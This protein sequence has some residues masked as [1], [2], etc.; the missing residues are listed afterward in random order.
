[1]THIGFPEAA[2]LTLP[3]SSS[4]ARPWLH[5]I[6]EPHTALIELSISYKSPRYIGIL[7]DMLLITAFSLHSLPDSDIGAR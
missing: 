5:S 3:R 2:T 1:M 7:F 4:G 6:T